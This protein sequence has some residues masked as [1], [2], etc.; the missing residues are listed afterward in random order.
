VAE[1]GV[2][3]RREPHPV[4]IERKAVGLGAE[5]RIAFSPAGEPAFAEQRRLARKEA[6]RER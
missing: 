1:A 5:R 3:G 2:T 6:A 4:A